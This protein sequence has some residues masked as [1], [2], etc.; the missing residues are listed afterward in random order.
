MS[1]GLSVRTAADASRAVETP[2][3]RARP[4][5]LWWAGASTDRGVFSHEPNML[6]V[7]GAVCSAALLGTQ[8]LA[9]FFACGRTAISAG[10]EL[11]NSDACPRPTTDRHLSRG[12]L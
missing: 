1:S 5:P 10:S 11:D 3:T 4:T 8:T 2:V 7:G 12:H 9:P 6:E